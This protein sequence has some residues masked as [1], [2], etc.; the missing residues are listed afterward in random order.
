[1][2][3]KLKFT[4]SAEKDWNSLDNSIKQQLKKA[5]IKR[6]SN[7]YVPK[8]RL[9]GTIV[10]TYKI[11]LKS[12]GIRLIY[13]VVENELSLIVITIGKRENNQVIN[14]LIKNY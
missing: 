12:L 14:Q 3:Y 5:L 7:P 13:T 10:E 2:N 8:D 6:L 11:K 9:H 1:M 4:P